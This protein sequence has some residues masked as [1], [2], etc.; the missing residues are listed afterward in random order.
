MTLVR[1]VEVLLLVPAILAAQVTPERER[2]DSIRID[3]VVATLVADSIAATQRA[4]AFADSTLSAAIPLWP[5]APAL[6]DAIRDRLTAKAW[7][8]YLN[9]ELRLR[10]MPHG[11]TANR[12]TIIATVDSVRVFLQSRG[13]NLDRVSVARFA[14]SAGSAQIAFSWDGELAVTAIPP[15]GASPPE[16]THV[17]RRLWFDGE[18]RYR[19]G[20]VRVFYAT[21][22]ER[23]GD[24]DPE[25]F[26]AGTRE[27]NGRLE[28][29][30]VEVTVPRIH[31]KGA[32]ERPVWYKL[33]RSADPN[34]HM[35]VKTLLPLAQQ[36][37]H[38]SLRGALAASGRQEALVFIHGYNVSFADAAMRTAQ[39]TYDLGFDGAPILYSWPS[40]GSIFRYS[41]DRE[42]AE[43]SAQHLAAFLDSVV[44]IAGKKRVHVIAHSMGNRVLTLALEAMA[45]DGRDT[46]IGNIVL[47][48]ADVD[49]GRFE[50][51]IAP[52]IRPLSRRMTIYMSGQ[53]KALR[54]SRVLSTN[55]RLGEAS[56]PMLVVAGAETVDASSID[57]D[58]LDHGYIASS[59]E[60][61][62]DLL[63][64]LDG[65]A[66]PRSRLRA[67]QTPGGEPFWILSEGRHP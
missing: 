31:R 21:D 4:R 65:K 56:S 8:L 36:A 2:Q 32:V 59:N 49:A 64:L 53:D 33:E 58:L 17:P 29:G 12:E 45:R 55:L 28:F 7:L 46:L 47:A 19:W 18:E 38:D 27:P 48:A 39:L 14:D 34:R 63:Q 22:R 9:R 20:T 30:R 67:S 5:E 10:I 6:T 43:F 66:P 42:N 3:S 15:A 37:L 1:T 11:S 35:T 61:V 13:L 57:V 25:K 50:Q 24:N 23:S 26:Y 16:P 60:V 40:R 44:A 52:L 51:Q 54:A 62:E 41:A